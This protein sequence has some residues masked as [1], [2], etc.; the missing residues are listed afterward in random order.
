MF[1]LSD[2]KEL[3]HLFHKHRFEDFKWI[4]P[5]DIIVSQ[6]VRIKCMFGCQEYG[7]NACCPPNTPL[8]DECRSFF[9]E[10]SEGVVFHFAKKVAKPEERHEW[11]KG[12]NE[13][14]LQLEREVFLADNPKT[15]L[16]FM[17]SC[18]L[19]KE[20]AEERTQCRNKKSARPSPDAMA[21]DVYSTVRQLGYP[22]QVL[23]GY[24]ETMNR[25]AFLLIK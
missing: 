20:C 9:G 21:V 19:C 2:R 22:I 17:D 8:V 6:W 12:I 4:N 25:Y 7:R 16:L 14:L 3:E 11:A 15:F 18:S 23:R 13:R 10:Y 24:S 5:R 1:V